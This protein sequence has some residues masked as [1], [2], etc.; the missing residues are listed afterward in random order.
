[1]K[2]KLKSQRGASI[3]FALLIF[4]VCAVIGSVVLG[5]GTAAAGRIS[6]LPKSD[7][8]YYS[9]TSAARLFEEQFAGTNVTVTRTRTYKITETTDIAYDTSTGIYSYGT[10]NKE[11]P[12]E[13]GYT[14]SSQIIYSF[15][16]AETDPSG[17]AVV[18]PNDLFTYFADLYVNGTAEKDATWWEREPKISDLTSESLEKKLTASVAD[19]AALDVKITA[20]VKENGAIWLEFVNKKADT[21]ANYRPFTLRMILS[22]DQNNST[23]IQSVTRDPELSGTS[24]KITT[25]VTETKTTSITWHVLSLE[26]LGREG[27]I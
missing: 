26:V 13:S 15:S 2:R 23:G 25:D 11:D 18:T 10:T 22:A 17:T 6:S 21:D 19:H 24:R 20:T 14:G 7:Q 16:I 3:T 4:L 8:R 1:M 27:S 5:A 9:V 12:T